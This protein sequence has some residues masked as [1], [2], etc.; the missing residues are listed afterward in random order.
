MNTIRNKL[1]T[2]FILLE[3]FIL[4]PLL[5][6]DLGFKKGVKKFYNVIVF[7]FTYPKDIIKN[8]RR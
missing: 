3:G 1:F 7:G 4:I 5:C 2:I 6:R 8:E